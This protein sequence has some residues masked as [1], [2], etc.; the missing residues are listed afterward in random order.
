[1]SDNGNG[2]LTTTERV[3]MRYHVDGLSRDEIATTM[4]VSPHTVDAH[5]RNAKHKLAARNMAQAG[6]LYVTLA[7]SE[8]RNGG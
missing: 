3:V 2:R 8:R 5:L 4:T 7:R 6:A 1:V